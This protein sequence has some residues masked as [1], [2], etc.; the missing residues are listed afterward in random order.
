VSTVAG[1]GSG[2]NDVAELNDISCQ[3][4]GENIDISAFGDAWMKRIQGRKDVRFTGSGFLVPGDTNGQIAVRA[5]L[6][7]DTELWAQFLW[8]G[9]AGFKA[10]VRVASFQAQAA[11]QGAVAVTIELEG[12]SAVTVV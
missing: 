8:D 5:A 6:I 4:N 10:Q 3:I 1:G 11:P 7:S 2:Y 9:V 12:T